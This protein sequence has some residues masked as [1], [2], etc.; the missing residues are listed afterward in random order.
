V[1]SAQLTI[2]G[3]R[4]D[5]HTELP[6][7]VRFTGWVDRAKLAELYQSASVFVLPS[8]FD[9]CPNV[10]REAMG[11][12]VPC[13]GTSCCA[14]PEIIEDGVSGRVVPRDQPGPLADALIELL[15][16]PGKAES[17]GRAAYSSVLRAG[18]WSDVA[19][20]MAPFLKAMVSGSVQ[21]GYC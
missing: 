14:I 12:G 20:R 21:R 3:P 8:I 17:M 1:P 16:E 6:A 7:G 4:Q 9:P 15:S 2:A 11:Y 19:E 18:R 5:S 10:F 13:I